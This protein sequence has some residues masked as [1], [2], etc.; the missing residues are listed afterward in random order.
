MKRIL[1]LVFLSTLG[2][3]TTCFGQFT[4]VIN[5]DI[6]F[7]L[8]IYSGYYGGDVDEDGWCDPTIV[9]EFWSTE[10]AWLNPQCFGWEC[11]SA[12]VVSQ[13]PYDWTVYGVS[14][15]VEWSIWITAFEKDGFD[16]C[17]YQP[18]VDDYWYG[19]YGI[20]PGGGTQQ[21]LIYPSSE[22][23]AG[24]W[25]SDLGETGVWLFDES[26]YWDQSYRLLWR[27]EAGDHSESP[28]NFGT[29]GNGQTVADHNSN[30]YVEDGAIDMFY[31]DTDGNLSRDVWYQFEINQN[32]HVT[33]STNHIETNF[34]CDLVLYN[35]DGSIA[36]YGEGWYDSI[37]KDLCPGVY[38]IRVEGNGGVEGDFKL[39]INSEVIGAMEITSSSFG[40]VSCFGEDDGNASVLMYGG[41]S[42][43]SYQWTWNGGSAQDNQV[44]NLPAGNVNVVVSDACG[45][46]LSTQFTI[47]VDDDEAPIADCVSQWVLEVEEGETGE[48]LAGY[49]NDNST[50]N[51]AIVNYSASPAEFSDADEGWHTVTLTVTDSNG[52]TASCTTEVLVNIVTDMSDLAPLQSASIVI[53]P[54]PNEGTFTV[55]LGEASMS[56]NALL[57]IRDIA[58]R[59]VYQTRPISG[60]NDLSLNLQSGV[61]Q[62]LLWNSEQAL[63]G[64]QRFVVQ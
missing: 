9:S 5:N 15:D 40:P 2:L 22:Y 36:A 17:T 64:V 50:D 55:D 13:I 3:V 47:V 48:V 31:L 41:I 60:L 37:V 44:N 19:G 10:T 45:T 1:P 34:D 51:C 14:F 12:C 58:G 7:Q 59:T 35:E 63:S 42:P 8:D 61:Y 27:Y 49:L 52:N 23:R 11:T 46:S 25:I 28:L 39:S 4:D 18:D 32:S 20:L 6:N 29:V 24:S 62:V 30:R 33:I 26:T 16:P 54:N 38:K 43:Y 57:E 53:Y 21:K 56:N